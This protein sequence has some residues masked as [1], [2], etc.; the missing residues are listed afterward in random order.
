V[1]DRGRTEEENRAKI[2]ALFF[3]AEGLEHMRNFKLEHV[4][5]KQVN[6]R[7]L[8]DIDIVKAGLFLE[9]LRQTNRTY[10]AWLNKQID[11]EL[12]GEQK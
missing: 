8:A 9:R 11:S 10:S 7:L 12:E 1:S 2:R 5:R 3:G 4:K 6:K